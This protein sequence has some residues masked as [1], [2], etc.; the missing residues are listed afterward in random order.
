M[1]NLA[2]GIESIPHLKAFDDLAADRLAA[3]D[4]SV[5]LMLLVDQAPAAA[6]PSLADQF[7]VLGYKGWALAR[8]EQEKRDLIKK[9]I[10]LHRYK[11]TEWAI[12]EA[13]KT[14]GF[15]N[16]SIV[17]GVGV[18]YDGAHNYDGSINYTGG[19]WA[20]FRVLITLPD[21]IG[22]NSVSLSDL[23][24]LILQYKNARSQ[25][26]DISFRIEFTEGLFQHRALWRRRRWTQWRLAGSSQPRAG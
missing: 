1:G 13:V 11:G 12:I 16:A 18:N 6:L 15:E 7:D 26:V 9:A 19:H 2:S 5:V 20:Q 14:V 4:I 22:V 24:S 10:E 8:N 21:N 3:I 25:L 23:T 17:T